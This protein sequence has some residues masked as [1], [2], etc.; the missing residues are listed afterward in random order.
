MAERPAYAAH[1]RLVAP[2]RPHG[3]LGRLIAGVVLAVV[4]AYGLNAALQMVLVTFA[5]DFWM[6]QIVGAERQGATAPAMYVL[7]FSFAFI[8]VGVMVAAR[9]VHR[10]VPLGV[11]GPPGLPLR[12]FWR[13]LRLLV[14]IGLLVLLLPPYDMG[15]DLVPNMAM[16]RWLLLL[17]LS[18]LAVFIQVTAE[19][20]L[21]RGYLQQSL[22][23]RFSHSLIWAGLPSALFAA[24]HYMP[25]QAGENAWIV[26]AW[27][28][29]F[30]LL[31]ADLTARAG[32]LGPAIALHFVN[33][34]T[35]LL[36]VSVPDSLNGLALFTAPFAMSDTDALRA[37]LPVDFA[38]MGVGWLAARV[39]LRR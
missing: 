2:A 18:L 28:G 17:P 3:T 35:S 31:A 33:N 25:A 34:A 11:I 27:A 20:I 36:I 5:P 4:V 16:R 19:E 32:T 10:R 7:L 24:G 12:Q 30:G 15:G 37:W 29:L 21:F 13:V 9:V 6:T 23:A 38:A 1:E 14:G 26:V 22:A 39:V 8:I